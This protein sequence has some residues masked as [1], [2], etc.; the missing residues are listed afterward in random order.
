M[1]TFCLIFCL[2]DL[3]LDLIALCS[4]KFSWL[5]GSGILVLHVLS[6]NITS[7]GELVV[8]CGVALKTYLGLSPD[9]S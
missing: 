8:V 6:L 9:S 7:D 1:S 3:S 2:V 4:S 5:R